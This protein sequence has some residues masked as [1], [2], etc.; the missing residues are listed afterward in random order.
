MLQLHMDL[1]VPDDRLVVA[2]SGGIDSMV[3]LHQLVQLQSRL[4]LT[5]IVAHMH[6]HKRS[7]ADM[8]AEFVK[9]TAE[10]YQ[11]T[12]ERGDYVDTGSGNFHQDARDKRYLFF[13]DIARKHQTG[14]IVLAHHQDDQVETIL[15]RLVRGSSFLGYAGIPESAQKRGIQ[16]VRPLLGATREDIETYAITYCIPYLEDESNAEDDYT[17]NRYRHH[18]IPFLKKEN[19]QFQN[20][21]DQFATYITMAHELILQEANDF[22]AQHIARTDNTR[23]IN[24]NHF[25]TLKDIVKIEVCSLLASEVAE[26]P[27]ELT[28]GQYQALLEASTSKKPMVE[29]HLDKHLFAIKSYSTM[30][31]RRERMVSIPF[32]Y[33]ITDLCELIL[34]DGARLS[35]SRN[36]SIFNGNTYELWYNDLDFIFPLTVRNR[37]TGD[38]VKTTA[39]TKKVKDLFIDKKVPHSLRDT[40]PI[41]VNPEGEIIWIPGYY[42]KPY[43][44]HTQCLLLSYQKGSDSC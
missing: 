33:Q 39:G 19:P 37:H 40:L 10:K 34:P 14:K 3:L 21:F 15:M 30:S 38:R 22:I 18:L 26:S 35:L 13:I 7:T 20:K 11:L 42:H 31:L 8:E 43:P 17:R 44:K 12:Y 5:L 28:F 41:I 6:H 24:L 2:V 23:N 9:K 36:N 32:E 16:V 29:V 4:R 27:V 1:I 25:N